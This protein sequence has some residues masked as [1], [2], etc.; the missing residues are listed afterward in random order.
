MQPSLDLLVNWARGAGDILRDGYGKQHNINRKGRIDLVTEVDQR[1]EDYLIGQVRAYFPAHTIESEESGLLTGGESSRWYIDPLDGTTNYAHDI[2]IFSVSIA[3][4]EDGK[5]QLGVVYDP[6]RDECFTAQRGNGAWLNG[7]P[8]HVSDAA[9]FTQSLLVTGF[10]YDLL[11][12]ETN[13]LRHFAHFTRLTQG[14]RRMGSAAI[15]LCYVAAGR[16]DG[17]WELTLHSWDIAAGAL[18]VMESGGKVSRINGEADFLRPPCSI[19]AANPAIYPLFVQE[20][21]KI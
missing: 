21:R 15:D 13:N 12:E 5:L 16:F 17:Y 14:V 3:Y 4:E 1:S 9:E 7:E 19:L 20:M 8:I 18:I 2:P 11:A 10:P 6:M